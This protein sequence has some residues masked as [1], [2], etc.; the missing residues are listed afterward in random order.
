MNIEVLGNKGGKKFESITS[1][2]FDKP[3]TGLWNTIAAHDFD[4]DGDLDFLVG[5]F[6]LNSQ[7]RASESEPLRLVYKDF[8]NNGS[9]DPMLTH[10]IQGVEYPFASRDELLDQIYAMRPKFTTYKAYADARLQD[11]FSAS[12][13]KNANVLKATVLESIYLE[14]KAGKLIA[15]VLP[16][17]AQFAPIYTISLAD[18][19]HDGNMDFVAAGN[20]SS[21]RIRMGVIDANFGQVFIGDGKGNFEYVR[22]PESGLSI[23]GDV[24]STKV[25]QAGGRE[26]LLVG[27][28]N[29][30]IDCYELKK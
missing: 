18:V 20:Q 26:Y 1:K 17:Q 15:H 25:I 22:Q 4:K 10:Y 19:N 28:N 29:V 9:V 24:K 23:T 30:G 21:I 12:D 14:N 16:A 6:G 2:M 7:L 3:L 11:I 13:L 27:I 5:N 8:D